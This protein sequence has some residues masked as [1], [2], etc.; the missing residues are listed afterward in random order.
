[1]MVAGRTDSRP[2]C[3]PP[4][5]L[6]QSQQNMSTRSKYTPLRRGASSAARNEAEMT[7]SAAAA[8]AAST[9]VSSSVE[10]AAKLQKAKSEVHL[11]TYQLSDSHLY[12]CLCVKCLK[13]IFY[14][15][16]SQYIVLFS[17]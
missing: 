5:S 15:L 8:A 6:K 12:Y 13:L 16:D 2:S 14:V 1:M 4:I 9:K 10:D 7:D 3:P 11:L 17:N